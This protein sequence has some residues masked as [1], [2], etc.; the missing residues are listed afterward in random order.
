MA[1]FD[2]PRRVGTIRPDPVLHSDVKTTKDARQIRA[3]L[4]DASYDALFAQGVE[5]LLA[6]STTIPQAGAVTF[7]PVLIFNTQ[8]VPKFRLYDVLEAPQDGPEPI[9]WAHRLPEDGGA[10]FRKAFKI[11]GWK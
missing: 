5:Y 4:G 1:G 10:L 2:D 7:H 3:I 9:Y 6:N 11:C 8:E